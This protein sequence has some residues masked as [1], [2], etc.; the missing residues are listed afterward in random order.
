MNLPIHC[1]AKSLA[2]GVLCWLLSSVLFP[3]YSK[4]ILNDREI[5]IVNGTQVAE[6]EYPV[7]TALLSG[8]HASIRINGQQA[9]GQFFGHG[10]QAAFTGS[11]SSCGQANN[12]CR[13]VEGKICLIFTATVSEPEGLTPARQLNNCRL[14]GGIGAVFRS[15][16]GAAFRTELFDGDASIPAVFISDF[17][18]YAILRA[19]IAQIP[20]NGG[21]QIEVE[22]VASQSIL[23]GAAYLGNQWL[24]TA[25]HCVL[26]QTPEG[27]RQK[28]P[29]E[30]QASVGAHHLVDDAHL[31]QRV[32]EIVVNDFQL[33]G[34]GSRNDI[35]LLKLENVPLKV[36]QLPMV[37]ANFSAGIKV[38]SPATVEN[39]SHRSSEALVL[40]WGSTEVRK[41]F[42][43]SNTENS[44]SLTPRSALLTLRPTS[45]CALQWS[46]FLQANNFSAD[47]ITLDKGHL[48]AY[49]PLSQRD[50]CQGDSGGPLFIEVE[51]ALELAGITSF[52]LGCGSADGVP[53]VYTKVGVYAD[54]IQQVTGINV[55]SAVLPEPNASA[56]PVVTVAGSSAYA[57]GGSIGWPFLM[58]LLLS[59]RRVLPAL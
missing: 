54:W 57:G 35:A 2:A 18:S 9:N 4:P 8:R 36:R 3:A 16:I 6:N 46:D 22:P 10:V 7:L 20:F 58:L 30:V 40:G 11:L 37:E 23:C 44:T 48:C 31:A 42:A 52:G 29:W 5:A 12:V 26:E 43:E 49:E 32:T 47:A 55:L 45:E 50:T 38:S 59:R 41:P 53:G 28:L 24:V 21:V 33:Q 15:D 19:S 25:A 56:A 27:V 13:S 34:V 1:R 14:G 17:W 51:S 39:Q